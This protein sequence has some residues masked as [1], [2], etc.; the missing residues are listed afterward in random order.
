MKLNESLLASL[1]LDLERRPLLRFRRR[2]RGVPD[3]PGL[4][5]D[6]AQLERETGKDL[7]GTAEFSRFSGARTGVRAG[8]RSRL[9]RSLWWHRTEV[10]TRFVRADEVRVGQLVWQSGAEHEILRVRDLSDG[11]L[12]LTLQAA[13]GG[14][15]EVKL[16]PWAQLPVIDD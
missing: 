3:R 16:A 4:S 7:T 13:Q 14:S 8:F 1:R 11:R 6:P 5:P 15:V 10:K 2:P 9:P 12:E